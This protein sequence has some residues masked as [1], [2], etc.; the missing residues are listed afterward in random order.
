MNLSTHRKCKQRKSELITLIAIR[1]KYLYKCKLHIQYLLVQLA[2]LTIC[3]FFCTSMELN[4]NVWVNNNRIW[5]QIEL[6]SY[7]LLCVLIYLN[8]KKQCTNRNEMIIICC[9]GISILFSNRFSFDSFIKEDEK[10]RWRIKRLLIRMKSNTTE[11]SLDAAT[12]S[13]CNS[14]FHFVYR[15][16]FY[17][18]LLQQP[19]KKVSRTTT[20]KKRCNK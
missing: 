4:L 15:I 12:V 19:T 13:I 1:G 18:N 17:E 5:H 11:I 14:M 16:L 9:F 8:L 6:K 2:L 3:F 7:S 10:K 20:R